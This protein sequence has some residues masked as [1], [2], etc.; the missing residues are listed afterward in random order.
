MA[1]PATI[2]PPPS[3]KKRVKKSPKPKPP[4]SPTCPFCAIAAAHPPS[5]PSRRD[6]PINPPATK[7]DD[8]GSPS[9][10]AHLFLSTKHVLAFLDIMPLTRGHVLVIARGHY[11]KLGNVG[12]EVGKELGKW[13]PILS[14]VV[15]RTVL[16]TDLDSRGE[17][18]AQWN[19]VQ[20]NGPRASQ[21][22]PHVHFHIIPRPPLDTNTPT[23]GGW[24]MFGRGQ[25]DELDDD[26]AQ[27]T[28]AQLRAELV[29]E[30]AR[31]KEAEGIDLDLDGEFEQSKGKRRGLEKL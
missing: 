17:D 1:P 7:R 22:V 23:K 12:V 16:G 26:E 6:V 5:P 27:E 20:N 15:T 13:L 28:V 25:R 18:P 9:P 10:Q 4:S 3:L 19:V 11:E 2:W 21:T 31:V 8:A 24:L 29:R 14:R 30:V